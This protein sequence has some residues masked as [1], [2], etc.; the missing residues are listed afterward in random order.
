MRTDQMHVTLHFI[1]QADVDHVRNA[2][3]TVEA[4]SCYISIR[5]VGRFKIAGGRTI[6]WAGV[7]DTEELLAVHDATGRALAT[8][9]FTPERRRYR[10]HVTLARLKPFVRKAV[11]DA[12]LEAGRGREFGA[13]TADRF[14]LYDSVTRED[15]PRYD[16][17]ESY[18]L[19]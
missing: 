5:D 18:P 14:V 17:I 9:G 12:F 3:R 11:T 7:D 15:G 16:E 6:L 4:G 10:P 13:C 2:L 19:Q 8:T 1:G